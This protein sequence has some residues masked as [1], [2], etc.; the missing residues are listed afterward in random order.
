MPSALIAMA[1]PDLEQSRET[2]DFMCLMIFCIAVVTAIAGTSSKVF[3]A[4]TGENITIHTRINL[5][6][7]ILR[8]NMGWHD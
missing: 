1:I 6:A 5:Y 3:F 8:K 2:T 4:I 7:S